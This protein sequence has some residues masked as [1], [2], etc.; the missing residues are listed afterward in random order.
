M[1]IRTDFVT[2]SSS[3]SYSVLISIMDINNETY[4]LVIGPD[5][6]GGNNGVNIVC[7]AEK[8][9]GAKN[10]SDLFYIIA[11]SLSIEGRMYSQTEVE[12]EEDEYT[13]DFW[14]YQLSK[15]GRDIKKKINND[16]NKIRAIEL[17]REFVAWGE[18]SSCFTSNIK[19]SVYD[20]LVTLAEKYLNGDENSEEE[21]RNALK[22]WGGYVDG[23]SWSWDGGFL[24]SN[25]KNEIAGWDD[26]KGVLDSL[27]DE[28]V[29]G[30]SYGYG[31]DD[32]AVE[33]TL[34]DWQQKKVILQTSKYYPLGRNES[35][36]GRLFDKLP[37]LETFQNES[38]NEPKNEMKEA[39][40]GKG[41]DGLKFVVTGDIEAFPDRDKFKKYIEEHGGKLV[42]SV[43]SKTDYLITNTPDSGTVKNKKA[44]E[45]GIKIIN[46]KQFFEMVG[47]K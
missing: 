41:I 8:I 31:Y 9:V 20:Y 43:S 36:G 12:D 39:V 44:R 22:N 10:L 6:G 30:E 21:F 45:L 11:S 4:D 7:S 16:I 47:D 1:K 5:D 2:N 34:I 14:I 3:S 18:Y 27:A 37:K 25:V 13:V 46:E 42:G 29:N 32:Y 40:I 26:D 24:C 23:E 15:Y 28:F 38:D 17:T 35:S 19:H 33:S